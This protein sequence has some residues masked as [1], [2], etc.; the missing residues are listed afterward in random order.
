MSS[1]T[2]KGAAHNPREVDQGPRRSTRAMMKQAGSHPRKPQERQ[3]KRLVTSKVVQMPKTVKSPSSSQ[4]QK[5]DILHSPKKNNPTDIKSHEDS[6]SI[7][8]NSSSKKSFWGSPDISSGIENLFDAMGL[9]EY[10]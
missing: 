1:P 8:S 7:K 10:I 5:L 3:T 2:R 4:K 6:H 9:Y